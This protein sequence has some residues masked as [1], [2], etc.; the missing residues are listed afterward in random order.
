MNEHVSNRKRREEEAQRALEEARLMAEEMER[1][2]R[3]FE[4]RLRFNRSLQ[5]EGHGLE[6]TQVEDKD[7]LIITAFNTEVI[8]RYYLTVE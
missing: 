2:K 7:M 8:D 1:K 4:E 5:V 6:H 3:E